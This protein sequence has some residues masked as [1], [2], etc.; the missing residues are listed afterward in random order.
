[1]SGLGA[2]GACTPAVLRASAAIERAGFPTVSI[3][4][5][6][7]L[8]QA[9]VVAR[10]LGIDDLKIA[11]YP[12][13]PMVD[14]SEALREKVEKHLLADVLDGFTSARESTSKASAQEPAPRDIVFRGDIDAVND[15]FYDAGWSDGVPIVPPAIDRIERFLRHTDAKPEHVI[16]VCPPD[17]REATVWNV[18]VT[19]VMAG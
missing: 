4:S 11:H 8:K 7:F 6:G 1:M 17:N 5:T 18:A 12:G 19:G 3:V 10:G 2:G 15:H 16:G 13:T 9:E 14:S